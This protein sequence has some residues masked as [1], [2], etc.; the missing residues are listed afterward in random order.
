MRGKSNSSIIFY[1]RTEDVI[2]NIEIKYSSE[3]TWKKIKKIGPREKLK[4]E[5]VTP[6][7]FQEGSL[8]LR[9]LDKNGTYHTKTLKGYT[10]KS[11]KVLVKVYI[12]RIEDNGTLDLEIVDKS[13]F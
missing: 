10:E 7:N 5:L 11:F 6:K 8:E 1:N 3:N 13:L 4:K 12:K 2:E 9:Y